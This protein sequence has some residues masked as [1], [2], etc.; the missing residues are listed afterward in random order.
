MRRRELNITITYWFLGLIQSSGTAPEI[1]C[2]YMQQYHIKM[3]Y[4]LN[5]T[6]ATFGLLTDLLTN[7]NS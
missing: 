1:V 3:S 2:V 6:A 4:T 5:I 7:K